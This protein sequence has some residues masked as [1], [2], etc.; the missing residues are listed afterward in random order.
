MH[1]YDG[2]FSKCGWIFEY[3]IWHE[4]GLTQ[5]VMSCEYKRNEM[6]T[7]KW[8]I[9]GCLWLCHA[10]AWQTYTKYITNPNLVV[11]RA[12]KQTTAF[13]G[14]GLPIRWWK[15]VA[16]EGMMEARRLPGTKKTECCIRWLAERPRLYNCEMKMSTKH[17][18]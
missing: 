14:F 11:T 12:C 9:W 1:V 2:I 7:F 15:P 10:H 18:I 13:Q 16:N 8:Y 6:I 17:N 4:K 5:Q 3:A